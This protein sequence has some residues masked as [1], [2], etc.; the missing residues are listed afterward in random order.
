[1]DGTQRDM[2]GNK[3]QMTTVSSISEGMTTEV[4]DTLRL[5]WSTAKNLFSRKVV[6]Y[7][8]NQERLRQCPHKRFLDLAEMYCVLWE[9]PKFGT[10]AVE[11]DYNLMR[12][13]HVTAEEVMQCAEKNRK[14]EDYQ[15]RKVDEVLADM[16]IPLPGKEMPLYVLRGKNLFGA[17]AITNPEMIGKLTE[18]MGDLFILPSSVYELLLLPDNGDAEADTLRNIVRQVNES[19]VN[20][21]EFLSDQV[22]YYV[23]QTGEV[24]ICK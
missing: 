15:I 17:A 8:R 1:M 23:R 24:K 21:D 10:V 9:I 3:T 12:R 13:W 20:K 2:T 6:N 4:M 14:T 11:V 7:E 5:D 16:G 19:F 18:G 22:Y